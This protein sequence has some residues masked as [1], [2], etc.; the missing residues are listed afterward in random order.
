MTTTSSKIEN[1]QLDQDER[2]QGDTLPF[3]LDT[4][5]TSITTTPITAARTKRT[6]GITRSSFNHVLS[7][8]PP[9]VLGALFLLAWYTVTLNG[10]INALILPGPGVVFASLLQ[11][12][13]SGL[14]WVHILATVE[15]SLLGFLLAVVIALPMGYGIAKSRF[16]AHTFQPYLAAGQAIPAIILAPFLFIWLGSGL[17]SVIVVCTLVVLFPMVVNTILGLRIIERELLEAARLE[18]AH[19]W[20]LLAHI[21]FPL[22]LPSIIAAVRTSLTLSITGALVGEFFCSPDKGLGALVLIAMNQYN[23][24]FMFATVIILAVLAAVYYTMT[25]LLVKLAEMVY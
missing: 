17:Q 1:A 10:R 3:V 15:E 20:S 6:P 4:S 14:Y 8:I 19:G 16:I 7:V 25:W 13:V 23:M 9:L 21:E 24:A 5:D 12:F 22:A 18:G 2:K 11:G